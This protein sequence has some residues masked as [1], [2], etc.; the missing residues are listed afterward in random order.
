MSEAATDL[1]MTRYKTVKEIPT[2]NEWEEHPIERATR[3]DDGWELSIDGGWTCWLD[4]DRNLHNLVP[5]LGHIL[6]IYG[7]PFGHMRGQAL[8]G[9]VLWYETADEYQ[10]RT[11]REQSERYRLS[12]ERFYANEEA[13]YIQRRDALPDVFR[14]RIAQREANN[15]DFAWDFGAYELFCC[16]QAVLFANTLGNQEAVRAFHD[17][18][19]EEQLQAMPG[20]SEEHSGNTFGAAC[21]LAEWYLVNPSQVPRVP[22]ALSPLVGSEAYGDVAKVGQ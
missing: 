12:R 4:D 1:R 19:W 14:E 22:G 18:P 10:E 16:E 3:E 2:D 8:D 11:K 20:M 9:Q 6:R 13:D 7:N 5:E 21:A 17:M 15:P